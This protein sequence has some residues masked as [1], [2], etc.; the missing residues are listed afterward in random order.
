METSIKTS[1]ADHQSVIE[2][3]KPG[4]QFELLA[5]ERPFLMDVYRDELALL[6]GLSSC[7]S[8]A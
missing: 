7:L 5:A 8:V 6:V 4:I 3:E 1:L 2:L